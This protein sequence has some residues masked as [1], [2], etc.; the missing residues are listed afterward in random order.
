MHISHIWEGFVGDDDDDNHAG[1]DDT[2]LNMTDG[3][4]TNTTNLVH[5]L[6]REMEQ[7]IG[8]TSCG[9]NGIKSIKSRVFPLRTAFTIILN[10]TVVSV[11]S[12]KI[13]LFIQILTLQIPPT[14]CLHATQSYA[15]N[16]KHS[17]CIYPS[18]N[19]YLL[20]L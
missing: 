17:R 14:C 4:G 11:L 3:H 5:I 19:I 16:H 12:R 18:C 10:I 7:L 1:L 8:G 2:S 20:L 6:E 15:L 9:F 13:P